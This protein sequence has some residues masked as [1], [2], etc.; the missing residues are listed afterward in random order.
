MRLLAGVLWQTFRAL[1]GAY[2]LSIAGAL[3][4]NLLLP[5]EQML[6][7]ALFNSFVHLL[8]IPALF[9][10]PLSLVLR[11][12]LLMAFLLPAVLAFGSAYGAQFLPDRSAEAPPGS[13]SL[14]VMS[15]NLMAANRT[16]AYAIAQIQQVDADVVALQEVSYAHAALL[17]AQFDGEY[18][19]IALH[20]QRFGTQGQ[21]ILSR[22]PIRE[23]AFSQFDFVLTPLGHQRTVL[24]LPGGT[25]IVVYN[26]HPTHPGMN[27]RAFD[28]SFRSRELTQIADLA[29]AE[30]LPVM[31][32]GDF[33]MPDLSADYMRFDAAYTDVYGAVGWGMG[34]TFRLPLTLPPLLRLDYLFVDESFTPLRAEVV[35]PFAGSD[36]HALWADLAF[37]P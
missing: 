34:W 10:F 22:Y 23:D 11:Q 15:F 3:L 37:L 32:V 26:I 29:H 18:E 5:E 14:R 21:G 35:Y 1:T 4:L 2:G 31:I 16:P 6:P 8:L 17:Q 9:L 13:L 33:N 28:P 24:E 20:P 25:P 12:W 27:N 19:Y 30:P 7:L 36:H